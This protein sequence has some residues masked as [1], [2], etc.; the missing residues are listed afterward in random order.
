[1][2]YVSYGF[3]PKTIH[4]L[5]RK[6]ASPSNVLTPNQGAYSMPTSQTRLWTAIINTETPP[7]YLSLPWLSLS[8]AIGC[9]MGRDHYTTYTNHTGCQLLDCTLSPRENELLDKWTNYLA[10]TYYIAP[11][12]TQRASQQHT[13]DASWPVLTPAKLACSYFWWHTTLVAMETQE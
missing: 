11:S 3:W 5:A 8:V 6:Y 2:H 7:A 1:M 13:M 12:Y 9:M 10:G 4:L